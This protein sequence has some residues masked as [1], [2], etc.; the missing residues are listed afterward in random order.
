[1]PPTA[2]HP[3][4]LDTWHALVLVGRT[5]GLTECLRLGASYYFD[6]RDGWYI[7]LTPETAER[8]RLDL[9]QDP[10]ARDTVWTF[11]GDDARIVETV[12]QMSGAVAVA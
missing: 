5:L 6:L 9:W 8:F 1:M 2:D 12:A 10:V 3:R 11:R 4:P 7:R